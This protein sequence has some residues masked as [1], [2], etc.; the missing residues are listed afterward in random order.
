M[1]LVAPS[2]CQSVHNAASEHELLPCSQIVGVNDWDDDRLE[3]EDAGA[4]A[5]TLSLV[6][7]KFGCPAL[8]VG[9]AL[10]ELSVQDSLC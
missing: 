7:D 6:R 10:A 5:E 2:R 3:I 4:S 8:Q 1:Q 9:L